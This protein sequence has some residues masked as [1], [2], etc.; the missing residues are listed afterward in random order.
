M[1]SGSATAKDGAFG[2]GHQVGNML[3]ESLFAGE[4][5]DLHVD[6]SGLSVLVMRKKIK[7]PRIAIGVERAQAPATAVKHDGD[8]NRRI[9]R[10]DCLRVRRGLLN[11]ACPHLVFP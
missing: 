10:R 6:P 4:R 2:I 1:S 3:G 9:A 8:W 11:L 7:P 5:P